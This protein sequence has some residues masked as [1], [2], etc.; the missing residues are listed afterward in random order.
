MSD[1]VSGKVIGG[2]GLGAAV[3]LATWALT[4]F[5]PAWHSGL[6]DQ[7]ATALPFV[8]GVLG[9][10]AGGYLA[11]HRATALEIQKSLNDAIDVIE[12]YRSQAH[13]PLDTLPSFPTPPLPPP[14]VLP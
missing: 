5:I 7:L 12:A 3:G 6:P 2:T 11:R 8:I 14:K 10:A 4:T 1:P 13:P 9:Y